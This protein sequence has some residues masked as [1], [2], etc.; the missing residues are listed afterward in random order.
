MLSL[1]VR[2]APDLHE[3]CLKAH[4]GALQL[5]DLAPEEGSAE[6][7]ANVDLDAERKGKTA[8]IKTSTRQVGVLTVMHDCAP[9]HTT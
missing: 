3:T 4:H 6:D 1:P 7:G 9:S 5:L 8:V 2:T